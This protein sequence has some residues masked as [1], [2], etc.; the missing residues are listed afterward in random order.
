[1]YFGE[2]WAVFAKG[3]LSKV[4]SDTKEWTKAK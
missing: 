1:M 4:K 2:E 3:E